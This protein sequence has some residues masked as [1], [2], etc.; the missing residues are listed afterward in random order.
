MALSIPKQLKSW[1]RQ[2]ID[3]TQVMVASEA[4]VKAAAAAQ[5]ALDAVLAAIAE[6]GGGGGGG[7]TPDATAN[8]KGK[9]RLSGDLS[10]TAQDPTVPAL[11]SLNERINGFTNPT[12]NSI[13]FKPNVSVVGHQHPYTDITGDSTPI[14]DFLAATD[15]QAARD[16]I[17]AIS[18]ADALSSDAFAEVLSNALTNYVTLTDLN[19]RQQNW[20]HVVF[21][22]ATTSAWPTVRPTPALNM[23]VLALG[24]PAAPTWLD[25]SK[26]DT[27]LGTVA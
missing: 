27:W 20:F 4:A 10:G 17:G 24:G 15:A 13:T 21:W 23:P 22:N 6:G 2:G 5:A 16:A 26:H 18:A 1:T 12:W 25:T 14:N 9:I 8:T 3:V 7:V 19:T 11:V